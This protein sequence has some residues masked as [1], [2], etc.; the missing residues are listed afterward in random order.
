[1]TIAIVTGSSEAWIFSAPNGH[2]SRKR[3]GRI[4]PYAATTSAA[5]IEARFLTSTLEYGVGWS[6]RDGFYLVILPGY[7]NVASNEPGAPNAE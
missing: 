6:R 4:I 3:C 7:V 5:A 1:M 2:A